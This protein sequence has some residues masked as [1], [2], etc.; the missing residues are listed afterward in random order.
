MTDYVLLSSGM[1]TR[2]D[3]RNLSLS[4][5]GSRIE[6]MPQ[7]FHLWSP[8]AAGESLLAMAM[9]V[10]C[11]DKLSPREEAADAWSRSLS[12]EVPSRAAGFDAAAF[13]PALG[14][15]TGDT[16][17]L[18]T[19][20]ERSSLFELVEEAPELVPLEVDAVSLFSGGLDSLCGV[21]DLLENDPGLRL[22]LVSHYD[23]GQATSRQTEIH[24]RLVETY[25]ADRVILRQFWARPAPLNL[26][27]QFEPGENTTRARSFMFI[28]A[29]LALA[30]AAGTNV[31]VYVPENGYIALN[32]PLTRA[33]VGSLSTR[34]THPHYLDLY[35]QAARSSG[36]S[37]PIINP[38]RHLTK[39]EMLDRSANKTLLMELA[40]QSISCSHPEVGRWAKVEQ[41]NCGYCFPCIIRQASMHAAGFTRDYYPWDVLSDSGLLGNVE[42]ARGADL[43]AVISAVYADR[44]DRD[45]FKNG[46]VPYERPE[47]LGVWRRGNEE[48]RSWLEAGASGDLAELLVRRS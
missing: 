44:P 18:T 9:S 26:G 34:T 3:R 29:A 25:G 32:V 42:D 23:G 10:Y 21:I 1:Q 33:R 22:A 6:W 17:S 19:R 20:D 14:F 24:A 38:Y 36:I 7:F 12:L 16:W 15:L 47:H 30:S 39:G 13:G 8:T 28:A 4:N 5:E 35:S 46:P 48:I 43:R 27:G 2:P 37:N 40:P 11:I 31:P 41:G 45:L